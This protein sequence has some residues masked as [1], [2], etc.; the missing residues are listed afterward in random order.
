[1]AFQ[2]STTGPTV[3]YYAV[4]QTV[5]GVVAE[6]VALYS[7]TRLDRAGGCRFQLSRS[8]AVMENNPISS[9]RRY[10]RREAST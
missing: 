3:R 9:C 2:L 5:S 4:G 10:T 6:K 1:M 7:I 8:Y